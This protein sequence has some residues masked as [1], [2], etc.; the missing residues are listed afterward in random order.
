MQR[1]KAILRF[2]D[3]RL[4][5]GYLVNFSPADRNISLEDES[6][7]R[8]NVDMT[9]LKAIFFVRTFQGDKWY[10]EKKSFRKTRQTGRR[11]F[12]RFKDGESMIGYIE[13]DLPWRKGFFLEAEKKSG[14]FLKPVDGDSNNRKVFVVA[15]SIDDVT[16]IG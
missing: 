14:F 10:R 3:K 5:K 4:I 16:T 15:T 11:V 6:S 7:K 2:L 13:G 9:V 8:H 1:E 12:V